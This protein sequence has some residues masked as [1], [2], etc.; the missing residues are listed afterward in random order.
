VDIHLQNNCSFRQNCKG[1]YI[2]TSGILCVFI[3]RFCPY[4]NSYANIHDLT[5]FS[6]QIYKLGLKQNCLFSCSS[7]DTIRFRKNFLNIRF[8]LQKIRVAVRNLHIMQIFFEPKSFVNM[9][10]FPSFKYCAI[11][12]FHIS[13]LSVLNFLL[14]NF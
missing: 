2:H 13:F 9:G 10:E 7:N 11:I 5:L 4:S 3:Y 1:K 8:S 6:I 12:A 14:L